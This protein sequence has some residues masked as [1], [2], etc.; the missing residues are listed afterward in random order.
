MKIEFHP[1][2]NGTEG[3]VDFTNALKG[4]SIPKEYVPGVIK[5]IESVVNS[6]PLA[7]FPV[8]GLRAI[9]LDGAYHD[10]DSSSLAFEIAA[11]Q[12]TRE[13]LKKAKSRL[14]E[15]IMKVDVTCPDEFVGTSAHPCFPFTLL[16]LTDS[17]QGM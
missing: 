15:P 6:G 14:K 8:M 1:L 9:L 11:R 16:R 3:Q 2:V 5:G 12:A 7:G 17:S 13:G 4:G 10:V